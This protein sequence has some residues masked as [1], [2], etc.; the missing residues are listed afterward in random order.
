MSSVPGECPKRCWGD[1]TPGKFCTAQLA[2]ELS[3][4]GHVQKR[5]LETSMQKKKAKEAADSVI[6]TGYSTCMEQL[7]LPS[8]K[9]KCGA[10]CFG[11]C[12]GRGILDSSMD[13]WD[14]QSILSQMDLEIP[15]P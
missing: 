13:F 10:R 4:N 12:I 9:K 2:Q 11:T 15:Q 7:K 8:N 14:C 3:T 5:C 1:R 6:P